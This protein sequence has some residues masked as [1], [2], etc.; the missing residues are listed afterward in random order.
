MRYCRA[1]TARGRTKKVFGYRVAQ[2]LCIKSN[3]SIH[4]HFCE[5]PVFKL[6]IILE[7]EESGV[8]LHVYIYDMAKCGTYRLLPEFAPIHRKYDFTFCEKF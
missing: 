5:C 2:K 1:E 6:G 4:G 3:I 8:N 7:T